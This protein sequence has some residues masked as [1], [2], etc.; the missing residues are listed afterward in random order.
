MA[1]LKDPQQRILVTIP[2][3]HFCEKA[4]W[5]LDRAGLHY[6]EHRHIQL[7]HQFAARRAGGGATAPVL[8][9][10]EGS[11]SQSSDILHYADEHTPEA[12]RLYPADPGA[13]AEVEALED[14]FGEIL[15][16]DA[17][18]WLYHQV[19][20]E[21]RHYA[22]WN[23]TGVPGWERRVFPFVIAPAKVI[24][25]RHFQITPESVAASRRRVDEEFDAVAE[26]LSDGRRYLVGDRFSAADLSFA[27]LAS[28]ALC[29]PEYGTPLPQPDDLR[30]EMVEAVAGW[31]AHPAGEF[32]LRLY[33]EERGTIVSA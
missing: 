13:R 18:R 33:R 30:G 4:R 27:A 10:S 22:P 20:Q 9:T 31:R 23:L 12:H 16:P 14:R 26:R 28:P 5:A 29:P 24:I 3:S 6:D 25:N 17:R 7:V 8:Q 19:F 32:G 21:P 2:I 1:R 15:G 11:Y